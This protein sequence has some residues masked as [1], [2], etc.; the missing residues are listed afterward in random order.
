M[1]EIVEELSLLDK[2]FGT[3]KYIIASWV[4]GAF[5]SIPIVTL[6][7]RD[8]PENEENS[9]SENKESVHDFVRKNLKFIITSSISIRC[10]GTRVIWD[11]GF[12]SCYTH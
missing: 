11:T 10:F 4:T 1:L 9:V 6:I 12:W 7:F 3:F 5:L 2:L 8:S